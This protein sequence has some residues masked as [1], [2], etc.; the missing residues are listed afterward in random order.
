MLHRGKL[1]A[2]YRV[3]HIKTKETTQSNP[4]KYKDF[5][6]RKNTLQFRTRAASAE[7]AGF[8]R[9]LVLICSCCEQCVSLNFPSL[10]VLK[11]FKAENFIPR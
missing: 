2:I 3:E 11:G 6:K 4:L 1:S 8:L 9:Q 5:I 7:V 10:L